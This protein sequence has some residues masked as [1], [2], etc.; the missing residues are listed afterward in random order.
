MRISPCMHTHA[1]AFRWCG[2]LYVHNAYTCA[3][4]RSLPLQRP[5]LDHARSIQDPCAYPKPRYPGKHVGLPGLVIH[6][7]SEP[8]MSTWLI[9]S[10]ATQRIN[11]QIERAHDMINHPSIK[12]SRV[13]RQH[14]AQLGLLLSNLVKLDW[15][16]LRRK[17]CYLRA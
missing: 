17:A 11:M 15:P 2:R 13:P 8:H 3:C 5:S 4:L 12:V 9:N 10:V 14:G 7:K 6:H 16:H 1:G